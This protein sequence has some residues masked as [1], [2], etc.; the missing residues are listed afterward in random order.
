MEN[1][2]FMVRFR[3][4]EE[5][6]KVMEVGLVFFDN[7]PVVMKTWYPELDLAAENVREKSAN[8]KRGMQKEE[9]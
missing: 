1:G 2:V 8:V 5:K 4:V 6:D 7:K 9:D 3:L